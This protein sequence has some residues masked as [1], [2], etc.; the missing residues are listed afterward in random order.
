MMDVK[1]FLTTVIRECKKNKSCKMCP[2]YKKLCIHYSYFDYFTE[3]IEN[4]IIAIAEKL[5]HKKTYAEDFFERFP[6]AAKRDDGTPGVC[7][8]QVYGSESAN[9]ANMP[10]RQCWNEP[11]PEEETK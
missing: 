8:D 4:E 2:F 9:C 11:F 3:E 7:R 1:E 5:N 6:N 10:C